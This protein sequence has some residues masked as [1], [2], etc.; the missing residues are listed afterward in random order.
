MYVSRRHG[1]IA[2]G[3][4]HHFALYLP[5]EFVG[6]HARGESG[7]HHCRT[8][9]L[10]RAEGSPQRGEDLRFLTQEQGAQITY[11][12]GHV[13]GGHRGDRS[14]DGPVDV[15]LAEGID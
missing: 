14:L 1:M 8:V 12:N 7:R 11:P 13:L 9:R 2:R 6:G 10:H 5:H 4:A 3:G 15:V